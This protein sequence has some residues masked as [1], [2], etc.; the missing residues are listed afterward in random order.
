MTDTTVRDALINSPEYV[1]AQTELV[2][3]QRDG[4]DYDNRLAAALAESAELALV[5]ERRKAR[6]ENAAPVHHRMYHFIGPI[7]SSSAVS[8]IDTFSRWDRIDTED[9]A[10]TGARPRPYTLV[11]SSQGGDVVAGFQAYSYLKGLARRRGLVTVAAGLCASMATIWHQ[12]GTERVIEPGCSYLLHEVSGSLG[13]RLDSIV[14]TAKWL[15]KMNDQLRHVLAERSN[16]DE[17]EIRTRVNRRECWLFPEDVVE[18]WGLAD[19]I[20]YA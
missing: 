2:R 3:S 6:W 17:E 12:A 20:D 7:D 16:F 8:L 11:I 5:R 9:E 4:Q 15:E 19:R 13:G 18:E 10:A 1:T 14:D